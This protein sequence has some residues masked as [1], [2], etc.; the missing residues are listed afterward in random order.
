MHEVA[1]VVE[2]N[3]DPGVEVTRYLEMAEPPL[4]VGAVQ[5]TWAWAIPGVACTPVGASGTGRGLVVE[6]VVP[7]EPG[8]TAL[9]ATTV[10]E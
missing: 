9:M 3:F 5:E 10:K 6:V 1:P 4:R 2:Q 8:F 7:A